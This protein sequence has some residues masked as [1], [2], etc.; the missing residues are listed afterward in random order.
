MA[1]KVRRALTDEERG[2]RTMKVVFAGL[3]L[4]GIFCFSMIK[5]GE[6]IAPPDKPQ[7]AKTRE[8]SPAARVAVATTAP[9]AD[10]ERGVGTREYELVR[11][12]LGKLDDKLYIN[13]QKS[14]ILVAYMGDKYCLEWK[15][16]AR[17]A[18]MWAAQRIAPL[19]LQHDATLQT[20]GVVQ[21]GI[22][23]SRLDTEVKP[24][25]T[26]FW[27]RETVCSTDWNGYD[28]GMRMRMAT[29]YVE[30]PLVTRDEPITRR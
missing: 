23:V 8:A 4:V 20:V 21:H 10:G 30:S 2:A 13:R 24:L 27:D 7:A 3:A 15:C 12:V 17:A 22:V 6:H 14:E 16:G 1:K 11:T 5:W 25:V 26:A 19:L 18:A 29:T 28:E 9:V